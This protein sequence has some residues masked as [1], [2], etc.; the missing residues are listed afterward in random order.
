MQSHILFFL[1]PWFFVL[2]ENVKMNLTFFCHLIK[3]LLYALQAQG[4]AQSL[5]E[6]QQQQKVK[7]GKSDFKHLNPLD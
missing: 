7:Q 4:T 6:S 5:K 1:T 3:T 2:P